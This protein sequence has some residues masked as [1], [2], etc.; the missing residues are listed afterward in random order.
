MISI[1]AGRDDDAVQLID[2][3][4]TIFAEYGC[5]L[6][7]DGELPELGTIASAFEK[8]GGEFW[9][10]ES[11]SGIVGCIGYTPVADGVEIR[12][13]YVKQTQRRAGLGDLLYQRVVAAARRR[14]V[15]FLDL[16][17]DTRFVE[18]HRFYEKR[19]FVRGENSRELH[20]ISNT[21]EYY[22]R[23]SLCRD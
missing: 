3:I 6:D 22:Y 4:G 7:V 23:K 1:R 13:L 11:E 14:Q 12:K 20:D 17:S 10:A 21:V 18:A 9:V 2:L 19:G 8:L 16:W 15:T 5:V